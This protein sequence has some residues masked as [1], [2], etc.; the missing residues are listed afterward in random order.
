MFGSKFVAL[1]DYMDTA[2]YLEILRSCPI[3]VMNH[4]RQQAMGNIIMM[5]WMGAR[6]FLNPQSPINREM[7]SIGVHVH[8]IGSIAEFL[9][10]REAAPA[11]DRIVDVRER[12][13]RRFGR[14]AAMAKTRVLLAQVSAL[15]DAGSTRA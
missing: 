13:D 15:R 11:S 10:Q 6:V 3:V 7:A 4:I 2:T 12:L 9:Q 8:D 5:L 1:R 14:D